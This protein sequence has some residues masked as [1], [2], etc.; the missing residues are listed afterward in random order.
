LK[1]KIKIFS[2]LAI[3]VMVLIATIIPF[4]SVGATNYDA[5]L[6]LENKNASWTKMLDDGIGATLNYNTSGTS[7]D[8]NLSATGLAVDTEYSLIYYTD[9]EDRYN[10]WNGADGIVIAN[11]ITESDGSIESEDMSVFLGMSMPNTLDANAYYYDYSKSIEEHG[12]GD[13]YPHAHGA[14]I[15]LVPTSALTDGDLP[16]Q[17]WPPTDNW[18]F[19]TDLISFTQEV[20]NPVGDTGNVEVALL[21]LSMTELQSTLYRSA[22]YDVTITATGSLY[23]VTTGVYGKIT[24]WDKDNFSIV[25]TS[26]NGV[27]LAEPQVMGG[28]TDN[29]GFW[30][31]DD[32]Y[33]APIGG[34]SYAINEVKE[35]GFVITPKAVCDFNIGIVLVSGVA[36]NRD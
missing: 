5:T 20:S 7:F 10:D 34:D 18:L 22:P 1:K 25:F 36:D 16:V 4:A 33:F 19:E 21:G 35:F 14:K 28:D 23:E 8:F 13:M 3:A 30:N 12:T 29:C 26:Y 9:T 6:L 32:Y 15:W 27:D 31:G 11:F 2:I 24:G 17:A